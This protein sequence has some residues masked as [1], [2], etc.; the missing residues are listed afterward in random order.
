VSGGGQANGQRRPSADAAPPANDGGSVGKY[1]FRWKIADRILTPAP[2]VLTAEEARRLRRAGMIILFLDY[3]TPLVVPV[4][5]L[6]SAAVSATLVA[7]HG[8][9]GL[10]TGKGIVASVMAVSGG[11]LYTG[12]LSWRKIKS[13]RRKQGAADESA[14]S[15]AGDHCS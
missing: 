11:I 9:H 5:S 1:D 6:V 3:C 4:L 14:D 13:K 15:S 12:A 10:G 7:R 8:W 2:G